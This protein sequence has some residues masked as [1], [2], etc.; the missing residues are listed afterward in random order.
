MGF[1]LQAQQSELQS[2]LRLTESTEEGQG[3]DQPASFR[4][5]VLD[6]AIPH[7]L[8][9]YALTL[10]S[11]NQ[12]TQLE[13]ES[14]SHP[15][16]AVISQSE[17]PSVAEAGTHASTLSDETAQEAAEAQTTQG[18]EEQG[19]A[20]RQEGGVCS[21]GSEQWG[22]AIA[23]AGLPWAL[24]LMAAFA[25]GHQV[26]SFTY[27]CTCDSCTCFTSFGGPASAPKTLMQFFSP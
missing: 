15:G 26:R 3:L 7:S 20:D 10:F 21:K 5:L 19:G 17:A 14:D 4:A 22:R 13:A 6:R 27:I 25:R 12:P 9:G 8:A 18:Q 1:V 11:I 16:P 23:M 2:L 24:Q